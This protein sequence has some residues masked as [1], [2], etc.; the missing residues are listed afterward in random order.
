LTGKAE[1]AWNS[2]Q[3]AAFAELKQVVSSA[4]A[5]RMIRDEGKLKI[6][7]NASEFATGAVLMQQ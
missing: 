6:K 5:M 3:E 1:W 2:A 7:K 4:L